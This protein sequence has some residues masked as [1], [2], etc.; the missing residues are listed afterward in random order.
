MKNLTLMLGVVATIAFTSCQQ[1]E[2]PPDDIKHVVVIGID[3]FS[4]SGLRKANP[5]FM[6]S[7]MSVG[8]YSLSVRTVLPTVSS[9]NW[10]SLIMGA[11]PAQH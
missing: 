4:A 9:P 10:A 5:A 1:K 3:G 7:L 11:G 2:Q 6:D 8:A